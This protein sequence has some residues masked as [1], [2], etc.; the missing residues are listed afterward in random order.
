M[1]RMSGLVNSKFPLPG[2]RKG[3]CPT[4]IPLLRFAELV[5]KQCGAGFSLRGTSVPLERRAATCGRRAE[6]PT[7]AEACPTLRHCILSLTIFLLV[8]LAVAAESVSI[9][10]DGSALKVLGWNPGAATDGQSL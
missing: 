4:L 6:V 2:L 5:D 7:Q 1:K 10:R 8:L 9:V 3:G